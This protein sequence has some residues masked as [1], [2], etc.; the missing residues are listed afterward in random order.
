[1]NAVEAERFLAGSLAD[2]RLT[3]GEKK[4][5]SAWLAEHAATEQ[6]RGVVRHAAFEL[7]RKSVADPASAA[8]IEWLEDAMRAIEPMQ[9]AEPDRASIGASRAVFSPGEACLRHIAERI[10]ATRRTLDLCVFTITDDRISREILDAHRRGVK[11]RIISDND[12]A[13][14][15]GSDIHRLREAGIPVKLDDVR[16]PGI[17][18]LT[19]HMHHKFA[20]FDNERLINGS[21]NWTRGA[22]NVNYEN[23]VDSTEPALIEAFAA[24]FK[25]LWNKF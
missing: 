8:V 11:V 18:G 16:G 10:S 7:A 21:Y 25:R 3:G 22:A 9:P 24:E 5:L 13:G 4:A 14:D 1:M 19:G 6:D 17:S 20:I 12:K 2:R 23:I 15:L